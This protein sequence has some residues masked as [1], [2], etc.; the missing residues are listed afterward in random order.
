[1]R[2][3]AYLCLDG[4]EGRTEEQVQLIGETPKRYRIVCDRRIKLA[5]AHRWLEIGKDVLVP[6][7]A[8]RFVVVGPIETHQS[9]KR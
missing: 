2:K 1:V 6:K 9:A 4:W 7:T 3:I 5:G 8:I